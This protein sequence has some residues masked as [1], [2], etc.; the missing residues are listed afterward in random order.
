MRL[1]IAPAGRRQTGCPRLSKAVRD[2]STR[3]PR[4]CPHSRYDSA[5][6]RSVARHRASA[7]VGAGPLNAITDVAGVRVGHTTLISGD[8][9]LRR[10]GPV[11]TG[12]TVD[13][14]ARWR[15]LGRAGLR[16]AR[17]AQRQRRADRAGVDPRVRLLSRHDRHHEHPRRRHRPRRAGQAAPIARDRGDDAGPCRSPARRTTAQLN[18]IDGFHVQ[19]EHVHAAL[20]AASSGPVPRA[21]SVAGRG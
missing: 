5:D 2:L 8:G 7:A 6:A 12:V 20:A 9:P 19:A 4:R 14:P 17:H 10:L 18:D 1:R 3:R 16:R 15:R 13:R 11:R 21:T